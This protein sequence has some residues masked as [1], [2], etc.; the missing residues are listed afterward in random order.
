M[1][2]EPMLTPREK[3]PSTG[4]PQRSIEPATLWQR[5]QALPT[6]LFRPPG[7]RL[8][9][10]GPWQQ[11]ETDDCVTHLTLLKDSIQFNRSLLSPNK[12][13]RER[14][15]DRQTDRDRQTGRN[16][17]GVRNNY[18]NY[19]YHIHNIITKP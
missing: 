1:E 14:E 15:T 6:E 8:N 11:N 19:I 12:A 10:W 13:E 7:G 9:H 18:H 4:C 17:C 2:F 16:N 3:I 5:A